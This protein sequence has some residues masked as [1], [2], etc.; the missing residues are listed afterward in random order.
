MH[1]WVPAVVQAVAITVLLLAV[2]W[3]SRRWRMLWLPLSILIGVAT[4]AWT[5]WYVDSQGLA[6]DPPPRTLMIWVG[7]TGL[8]MGVL[9]LGW[10]HIR[11]G[12]RGASLAAVPLCLLCAALALNQWVGYFPT[13]QTAW[14]QLTAGPLP[15]ETDRPPSPRCSRRASIPA[16]GTVV[17]VDI[18]DRRPGSSTAASWCTCLRRGTRQ[19]RRRNFRP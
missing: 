17:P 6:D 19:T 15:D 2:G 10:R 14:N 11:W 4:A 12:R 1:G 5:R 9:L 18:G 8:A 7:L 16:K 3:R 13:V